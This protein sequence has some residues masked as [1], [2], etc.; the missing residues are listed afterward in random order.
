[1]ANTTGMPKYLATPISDDHPCLRIDVCD[2]EGSTVVHYFVSSFLLAE[3]SPH[4]G[5]LDIETGWNWS[6]LI[7]TS[8]WEV[9]HLHSPG[10][11]RSTSG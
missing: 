4:H 9:A 5:G 3:L 2:H 7:L 8:Y 11:P 6:V 1:M 10:F